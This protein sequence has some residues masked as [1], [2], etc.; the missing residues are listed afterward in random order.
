MIACIKNTISQSCSPAYLLSEAYSS[1]SFIE[2][3]SFSFFQESILAM[4]E[5]VQTTTTYYFNSLNLV[6]EGLRP[7]ISLGEPEFNQKHFNKIL[8][9]IA[10]DKEHKLSND[11][12]MKMFKKYNLRYNREKF[13]LLCERAYQL[14]HPYIY[15]VAKNP[16]LQSDYTLNFL[17]VNLDPQNQIENVAQ[18]IFEHGLNE[19]ENSNYLINSNQLQALEE[20]T[21]END[22]I[23]LNKL[24]QTHTYK[25][26][27]WVDKN[28]N[29]Q[30]NLWYDSALVTQKSQI[31]TFDFLDRISKK[32]GVQLKLKDIRKLPNIYS[33]IKNVLHPAVPVYFRADLLKALIADYMIGNSDIEPKYFVYS[34]FDVEAMSADHLFD[35]RTLTYLTSNGYVFNKVGISGF[36]NNFFI[37][38]KEKES[39]Q[40]SHYLKLIKN[41]SNCI[42]RLSGCDV[43][44]YIKPKPVLNSQSVFS[45][46]YNFRKEMNETR[47][48]EPRKVIKSP[49]SQFV[50]PLFPYYDHREEAFYFKDDSN[51]PYVM[52]GRSEYEDSQSKE[53]K[54]WVA[55]PKFNYYVNQ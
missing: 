29:T 48:E 40:K 51:I 22:L 53:L 24:K 3:S 52:N 25:L 19:L 2:Q 10:S 1:I 21:Q 6:F 30:I 12:L 37:F 47:G 7:F 42:K 14:D 4:V 28:P 41:M 33:E 31:K 34:D 5:K 54:N 20:S 35:E 46:Y 9:A 18:N 15:Q 44:G 17:W 23:K 11:S 32:K 26:L 49:R 45:Q 39:L 27:N 13:S 8:E 43:N 36:E 38:N 50:G 55:N 16:V